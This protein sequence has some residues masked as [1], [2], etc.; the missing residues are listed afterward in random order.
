MRREAAMCRMRTSTSPSALADVS[1]AADS[2]RTWAHRTKGRGERE[3]DSNR[4]W[5][6][7]ALRREWESAAAGEIGL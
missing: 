2:A 7:Y 5:R 1:T 3:S 4:P 6:E